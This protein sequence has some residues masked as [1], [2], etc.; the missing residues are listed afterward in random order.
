MAR[1]AHW[2]QSGK[3]ILWVVEGLLF[4]SEYGSTEGNTC[5][6]QATWPKA[7]DG[8][9]H[10]SKERIYYWHF[11]TCI[12]KKN[13]CVYI[14]KY[15]LVLFTPQPGVGFSLGLNNFVFDGQQLF[16]R[17]MLIIAHQIL[18]TGCLLH[19]LWWEFHILKSK[20][21]GTLEKRR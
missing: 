15:W 17:L 9:S 19:R 4:W 2:C 7:S 1:H 14:W 6:A 12:K 3:I 5:I 11:A 16:Q 10:R 18:R 8:K 13:P 20:F 21:Q